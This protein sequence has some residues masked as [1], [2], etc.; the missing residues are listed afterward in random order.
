MRSIAPL[1]TAVLLLG[2]TFG[3]TRSHAQDPA[4][5]RKIDQRVCSACSKTMKPMKEAGVSWDECSACEGVFLTKS[6][7]DKLIKAAGKR[8]G[9]ADCA[10][11]I[12]ELLKLTYQHSIKHMDPEGSFPQTKG[13]AFWEKIVKDMKANKTLLTCPVTGEPYRGPNVDNIN[14]GFGFKTVM[15]ICSH[16]DHANI[17]YKPGDVKRVELDSKEVKRALQETA[18]KSKKRDTP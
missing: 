5:P 15:T 16:E 6:Q 12:S 4:A 1:L 17:A 11:R 14:K 7:F 3:R 9:S 2:P 8:K 13:S 10:Q 18:P